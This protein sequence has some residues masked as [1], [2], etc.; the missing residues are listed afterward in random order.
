MPWFGEEKPSAWRD[1]VHWEY[2]FRDLLRSEN[3]HTD[4]ARLPAHLHSNNCSLS[5]RRSHTHKYVHFAALEPLMFDLKN[6]PAESVDCSQQPDYQE[7]RLA[8]A[9]ALL[10]W[11][12]WHL[13]QTL[14]NIST[15]DTM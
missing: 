15:Q 1:H 4:A 9:E 2:D 14:A 7:R 3:P 10:S 13:D 6:D 5:V 12:A 11:R 8:N